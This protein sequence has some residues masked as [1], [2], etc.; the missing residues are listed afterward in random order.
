MNLIEKSLAIALKA[1]DGQTDKAEHSNISHP[2]RLMAKMDT[3]EEMAVALL[4][5]CVEDSDHTAE[6]LLNS[7]IPSTIVDA[8][9]SL[10]KVY[11]EDYDQFIERVMKNGYR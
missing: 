10:T 6:S 1:H 8:V 5:D 7:G 3:D 4:H 2:L 9:Q 11:G